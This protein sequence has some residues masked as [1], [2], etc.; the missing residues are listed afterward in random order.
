[1]RIERG[2]I[3][4]FVILPGG[5]RGKVNRQSQTDIEFFRDN[6]D[7]IPVHHLDVLK[8]CLL[9]EVAL[10]GKIVKKIDNTTYTITLS[11]TQKL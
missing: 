6:L 10:D 1:M 5:V 3:T 11:P 2:P 7:A 9:A 4:W 8:E